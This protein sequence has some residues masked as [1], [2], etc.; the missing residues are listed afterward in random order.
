MKLKIVSSIIWALFCILINAQVENKLP[1]LKGDYLGLTLP[2]ATPVIFARG[3]VSTDDKEHSAPYFS[4]DGNEVFWWTIKQVSEEKWLQF[5]RT[6]HRAGN[7]WTAP[8]L[9]ADDNMPFLSPDGKRLYYGSREE[10]EDLY[11]REKHGSNWSEAKFAGLVKRF[12]ELRFAYYP[13][14]AFNGTIYFMG[15]LEGQFANLGIYRSEFKNGEYSKPEL[16]PECINAVGGMRNWTPFI[17]PD[18]SYLLFCSTR[19]LPK[20][21]QGDLFISF[22][23]ADGN[24][25]DPVSLGEPINSKEMERFPAVSPDGKYLFFTRDTNLPGYVYDEDVYWVSAGIIDKLKGKAIQEGQLK[26]QTDRRVK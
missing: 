13:S 15:Y 6:M 17:A 4:L 5:S 22:H 12:P 16:L 3:I 11:Y 24:W 1:I 2:G 18:E 21:D 8:E 9:L 26:E 7:I 19:G 20:S 23:K 10:G 25:T 14:V